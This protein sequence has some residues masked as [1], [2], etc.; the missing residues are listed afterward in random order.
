VV[1]AELVVSNKKFFKKLPPP[2]PPLSK[3]YLI[4]NNPPHPLYPAGS[5]K[6]EKVIDS[7]YLSI[8]CLWFG[9]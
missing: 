2:P 3:E 4:T 7:L 1:I 8:I 6:K 9:L 5:A